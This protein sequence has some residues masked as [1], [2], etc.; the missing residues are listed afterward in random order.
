MRTKSAHSGVL[1]TEQCC[2]YDE[3]SENASKGDR[4]S[5][6]T[7]LCLVDGD[8]PRLPL[9]P[10]SGVR[11]GRIKR[12]IVCSMTSKYA[13]TLYE[14]IQL[15]ANLERC[16]KTF[17]IDRFRALL[18]VPPGAYARGDNFLRNV[19]DP[20]SGRSMGCPTWV[21]PSKS[22]DGI[23]DRR[24]TRLRSRG[25][26]SLGMNSALRSTNGTAVNWAEWLA[27]PLT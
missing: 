12:E 14:L 20:P 19:I 18:G 10:T 23:Q 24:S 22:V 13:I 7:A 11:W 16:V 8:R 17:P 1:L 21:S 5:G 25:G 26:R 9:S 2:F 27:R 6:R 15:G 4:D 3:R